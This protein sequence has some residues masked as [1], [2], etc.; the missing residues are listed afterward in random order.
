MLS[1]DPPG[2]R[3]YADAR[4]L[5]PSCIRRRTVQS[6][7]SCG[8]RA[9]ACLWMPPDA[10]PMAAIGSRMVLMGRLTRRERDCSTTA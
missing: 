3:E 5:R 1:Y 2:N 9:C 7:P 4:Q 10:E 6:A 8:F